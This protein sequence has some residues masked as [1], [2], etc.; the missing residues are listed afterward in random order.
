MRQVVLEVRH[1]GL[2]RHILLADML[3]APLGL[4]RGSR[5]GEQK[6]GR[7]REPMHDI[8]RPT[9]LGR[10]KEVSQ[11][12]IL[13]LRL[14]LSSPLPPIDWFCKVNESAPRFFQGKKDLLACFDRKKKRNKSKSRA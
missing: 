12:A 4:R 11:D 13:S 8:G 7:K 3:E 9:T 6:P 14:V 5:R 2:G 1:G 10:E